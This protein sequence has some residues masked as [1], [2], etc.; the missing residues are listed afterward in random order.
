MAWM[1]PIPA[2]EACE[3]PRRKRL[4]RVW[5]IVAATVAASALAV[6][7][8]HLLNS[9]RMPTVPTPS[10]GAK[11]SDHIA[12]SPKAGCSK[13]GHAETRQSLKKRYADMSNEEKLAS[14]RERYGDDIP[15]NMKA[16]VH[17]LENPP[18][19]V[20]RPA[21]SRESVFRHESERVIA[22]FVMTEPGTWF[23]RQPMYD[24]RIDADF[25]QAL[26]DGIDVSD[27]DTPEQAELKRLVGETRDELARRVAGG[28][29][30]SDILNT[31]GRE[32]YELGQFRR[33]LQSEIA[34][35]CRNSDCTDADVGELVAAANRM[36]RG[37]GLPP[38]KMPSLILRH[39]SLRMAAE[40]AKAEAGRETR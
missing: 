22:S 40:R 23:M 37:K 5:A 14:I 19:Q 10:S 24:D 13:G 30:V 6:A 36:L 17:F 38:L 12:E 34:K 26:K 15:D 11:R 4:S 33:E 1:R 7:L 31:I 39:V 18:K 16:I 25:A 20:F 28:E 3:S 27:G 35:T 2:G 8:S 29:K 9:P 21:R 32:Y